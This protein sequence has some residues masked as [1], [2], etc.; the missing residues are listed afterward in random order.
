M[1]RFNAGQKHN[2]L[3][4]PIKCENKGHQAMVD[5]GAQM[6]VMSLGL[7]QN[8]NLMH[9]I[10]REYAGEAQGVGIAE[11]YGLINDVEIEIA[12]KSYTQSF[13]V[14]DMGKNMEY[15]M[16][17]GLDFLTN[18]NCEISLRTRTIAIND[19]I[20]SFINCETSQSKEPVLLG[21]MKP[22][23]NILEQII[24]NIISNPDE[25]KY[26]NINAK[27]LSIEQIDILKNFNFAHNDDRLLF[28][29]EYSQLE[30][31]LD[32]VC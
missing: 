21:A 6:S 4:I 14:M 18:N 16:L 20:V 22:K 25:I 9:R 11:I 19:N 7:A 17:L 27:K 3:Y 29:G 13:R 10:R 2:L 28:I 24:Y 32:C 30:L 8:L 5:T 31:A 15:L 1:W 26:R 12:G 23:I